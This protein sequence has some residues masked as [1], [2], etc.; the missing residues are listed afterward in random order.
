[1]LGPWCYVLPGYEQNGWR[2]VWQQIQSEPSLLHGRSSYFFLPSF[3]H[4]LTHSLV[5]L[6]AIEVT[7]EWDVVRGYIRDHSLVPGVLVTTIFDFHNTDTP[8]L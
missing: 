4:L 2:K 6:H 5:N 7:Q 3:L 1:M 8:R